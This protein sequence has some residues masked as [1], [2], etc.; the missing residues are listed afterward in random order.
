MP[1]TVF[2]FHGHKE[3]EEPEAKSQTSQ[4]LQLVSEREISNVKERISQ[5]HVFM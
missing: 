4:S 3:G 2:K 5:T 1:C